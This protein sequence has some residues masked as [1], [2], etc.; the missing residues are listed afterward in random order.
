MPEGWDSITLGFLT[1]FFTVVVSMPSLIKI[2]YLKRLVDAPTE[3][4][5]IHTRNVP[6]IGGI[7][8]FAGT[9]FAYFLWYPFKDIHDFEH[10]YRAIND[11]KYIG[12]TMLILFFI[13]VKDDIIGTAAT[14]K[15][16]GHIIVAFILVVMANIRITS[17]YGLFGVEVLNDWGSIFL[18][19]FTYIVLVNAINLID[20]VDGLAGGVS[21]IVTL[22]FGIWFYLAGGIE[23]SVLSFALSG[24]LLGFLIFNFHPAK[25]F[26]GDSG[27][28][29]I[30]LIISVLAIKLI[31]FEPSELPA[32]IVK[33]SKPVFAMAVLV[34]PLVDTFR[35]FFIRI[36]KGRSPFTADKN[37]IHHKLLSLGLTH[38]GVALTIYIYTITIILISILTSALSPSFQLLITG[39]AAF[40]FVG[41]IYLIPSKAQ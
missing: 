24:A 6:S 32:N 20:G 10:L 18:S 8:I 22:A 36:M 25:I 19:A 28:L 5:K 31:E 11:F 27:S 23:N 4:R 1:A 40:L 38:R 34:Y 13:G 17:M 15:L 41:I 37:H 33:L 12:A 39:S 9:L 26:M 2:A 14:K 16:V 35:V 3:E 30:G 7:L 29:I 21:F